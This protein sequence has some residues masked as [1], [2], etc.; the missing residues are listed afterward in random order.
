MKKLFVIALLSGFFISAKSQKIY[1]QGGINFANITSSNS[2]STQSNSMLTSFNAGFMARSNLAQ[3]LAL[4]AG[5]LIDGRG[6]KSE[7]GSG[8][9]FY[10]AT[11]N[12]VYLELPVNLIVRLP[13]ESKSNLFFNAGPYIAMG[14]AGKSKVNGMLA[15]VSIQSTEDIKFTSADPTENDQAYSKL[16][17]FDYGINI[18]AGFDLRKVIIKVNYGYGLSKINSTQTNN[19][20]NDKNKYR[21][22][23]VS[24]GIPLGL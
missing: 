21:I 11:F 24:L 1:V 8:N 14:I 23:S 19:S 5:L 18:G 20:E 2:G 22:V 16:K 3:P 13:L 10:K 15:G 4:E 9:N 7:S 12:P 6:A 17:R